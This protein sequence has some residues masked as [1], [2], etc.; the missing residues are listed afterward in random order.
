[1]NTG[2]QTDVCPMGNPLLRTRP[3]TDYD[4]FELMLLS[5]LTINYYY[6]LRIL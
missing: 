5:N 1:M 6:L 4:L 3:W 2:V